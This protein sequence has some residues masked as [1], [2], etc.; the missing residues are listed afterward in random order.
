MTVV[1]FFIENFDFYRE[2]ED[3]ETTFDQVRKAQVMA[4][5]EEAVRVQEMEM[6]RLHAQKERERL[7]EQERRRRE[8]VSCEHFILLAIHFYKLHTFFIL[9]NTHFFHHKPA[10]F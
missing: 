4:Q 9:L 8:A 3:E 6:T 7:K 2:R 1:T 5:H 10:H